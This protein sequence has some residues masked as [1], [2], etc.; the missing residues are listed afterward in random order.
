METPKR[1]SLAPATV[2]ELLDR[3]FKI[4]RENFTSFVGLVA[5]VTIPVSIITLI[6]TLFLTESMR[7]AGFDLS[8]FSDPTSPP[9]FTPGDTAALNNLF[10]QIFGF[11]AFLIIIG[12]I[13][14]FIQGVLI[15][16]PLSYIASESNLG[17][18]VSI[19]EAFRAARSRFGALASGLLVYYLILFMLFVLLGLSVFVFFL[20]GLAPGIVLFI[21]FSLYAFL[22][23]VLVLERVGPLEGISRAWALAKARFWP[24]FG[25]FILVIVITYLLSIAFNFVSSLISRGGVGPAN[26]TTATIIQTILQAVT[27]IFIE[28]ILPIGFTLMYYDARVRLEGLDIAL[29][30]VETPE[31]R[32]ADLPSPPAPGET[33]GRDDFINMGIVAF[34]TLICVIAIYGILFAISAATFRS[35]R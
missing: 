8:Q 6:S 25:L 12:L 17:R 13:S 5:A 35:L 10:G 9:R 7:K 4:Y 27:T 21:G 23:P 16:G 3:T 33:F 19:G 26:F 29:Q 20:C 22:T 30:N 1:I 2:I 18:K 34:G 14:A 15:N 31:P 28:P 24:T 32:P 11:A